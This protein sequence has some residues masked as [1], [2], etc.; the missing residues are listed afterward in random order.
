MDHAFAKLFL[1]VGVVMLVG[2]F[3]VIRESIFFGVM[4]RW[5]GFFALVL[6]F[7]FRE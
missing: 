7:V 6:T 3:F 2:S 1:L 5:L 4:M